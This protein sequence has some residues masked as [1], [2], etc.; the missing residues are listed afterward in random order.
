VTSAFKQKKNTSNLL[1]RSEVNVDV[2]RTKVNI[3]FGPNGILGLRRFMVAVTT[4]PN[5]EC[6]KYRTGECIGRMIVKQFEPRVEKT[7]VIKKESLTRV[8]PNFPILSL[9]GLPVSSAT[10]GTCILGNSRKISPKALLWNAI[11]PGR[12]PSFYTRCIP[13]AHD[14]RIRIPL[15]W[16]FLRCSH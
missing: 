16:Q 15:H 14:R 4:D 1:I 12:H 9:H 2:Q 5:F 11:P 3:V 7:E 13:V 6:I 10:V 8:W